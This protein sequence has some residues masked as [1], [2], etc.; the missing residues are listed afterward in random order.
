[1]M[2]NYKNLIFFHYFHPSHNKDAEK[3]QK[4][5][6]LTKKSGKLR[7]YMTSDISFL[8]WSGLFIANSDKTFLSKSIFFN[9][10][11]CINLL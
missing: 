3:K 5:R 9:F 11:V 2:Q 1:M 10:K 4:T 6:F 8:N 7:S